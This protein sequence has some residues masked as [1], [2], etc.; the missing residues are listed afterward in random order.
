MN[1]ILV[2]RARLKELDG[3]REKQI[4]LEEDGKQ[5]Q[6]VQGKHIQLI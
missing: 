4:E 1:K 3:D 2:W 5:Q 6:N